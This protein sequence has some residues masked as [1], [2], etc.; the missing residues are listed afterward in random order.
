M[1]LDPAEARRAAR[2][3]L[4]AYA[5]D[6]AEQAR[7]EAVKLRRVEVRPVGDGTSWLSAL[8]PELDALRI[9]RRL[10]ALGRAQAADA[11]PEDR[12][13]LDQRRADL[14]TEALLSWGS[15][16]SGAT[17]GSTVGRGRT[18]QRPLAP[19]VSVAP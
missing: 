6:Q 12:R 11:T 3:A 18:Q 5:P 2:A 1:G 17:G 13:L 8:L 10:S 19:R 9:H 14:L 15:I 4:L 16:T 7:S